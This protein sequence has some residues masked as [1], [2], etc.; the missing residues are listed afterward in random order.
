MS[1]VKR[2]ALHIGLSIV[3]VVLGV[4]GMRALTASR[5]R[6]KKQRPTVPALLV[7]TISVESKTQRVSIH[8]EGTVRPWKQVDLA[9][10]VAGKVVMVSPNLVNGGWFKQ[11]DVLVRIDPIDYELAVTLAEARVKDAES[12]LKVVCA[13]AE[14][15]RQEWRRFNREQSGNAC[16]PPPLVAKEPQLRAAEARLKAEQAELERAR[17]NLKRTRIWAPFDG[18]VAEETVDVGQYLAPGKAFAT[19]YAGEAVEVVLPIETQRLAW[20]KVPGFTSGSGPGSRAVVHADIA[21]KKLSWPGRIVRAEGKLDERSRMIN[22]VVRVE[23]PYAKRPPLA[24]GLFVSVDMAGRFLPNAVLIPRAA[25]HEGRVVWVVGKDG[26]LRFR[27]VDVALVQQD[28][29]ILR[30][31]LKTG[32]QV[33]ITPL[34]AVTDGMRVHVLP[35]DQEAGR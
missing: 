21:G 2:Q 29:A 17:L 4:L 30:S 16:D 23:R 7:R 11:G 26:L 33:V 12:N 3:I 24:V 15:A 31:G 25:L 32:D 35:E 6:I 20:L 1:K 9:S 34:K 22:V 10:E 13:D 19:L 14:A 27:K 18:R 5:P 8:A 28:K